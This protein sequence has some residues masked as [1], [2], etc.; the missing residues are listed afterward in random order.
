MNPKSRRGA[1]E[2][3]SKD[4]QKIFLLQKWKN[5]PC[6]WYKNWTDNAMMSYL[7]FLILFICHRHFP[8]DNTFTIVVFR[9]FSSK[10]Y[11]SLPKIILEDW[12]N[13]VLWLSIEDFSPPCDYFFRVTIGCTKYLMFIKI[14]LLK[15]HFSIIYLKKV[16]LLYFKNNE[17][18]YI[19]GD[20]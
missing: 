20:W 10:F 14:K 2:S 15:N 8:L 3:L 16:L 11:N 17:T 4:P 7:N 1:Y 18:Y 12:K 13:T 5:N 6:S 19:K 9:I